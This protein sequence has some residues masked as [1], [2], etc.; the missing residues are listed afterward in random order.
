MRKLPIYPMLLFVFA[1][2]FNTSLFAQTLSISPEKIKSLDSLYRITFPASDPGAIIILAQGGKPVFK[3]A[4]GMANLENNVLL[5]TDHKMGI[6]SI[7]KQ[8]AAISILLLQQEGKLNIKDDIRKY[9]PFYNS[10]GKIITIENILSHTSGIPSYTE[11]N[12][13]D[14]IANKIIS[15]Y[16]L[17]KF[18]EKQPLLFDPGTNWSYT[19]SGYVLAGLIVEK[20]SGMSFNDFLQQRI[21]KPLLMTETT[22]GSSAF[23]LPGKS[24]EYSGPTPKGRMKVETQYNWYWAYAAGQIVSTV[25]DMLK[26]DEALYNPAFIRADLL[27]IAHTSFILKSGEDAH[28]G[29]GWAISTFKDKSMIQHGGSIG[30]YRAQGMRVPEDHLY[31]LILS[32]S[33]ITNASLTANKSLSILYDM[34]ALKENRENV[35][36]WKE[37]EG[38]YASPNAGLRLQSNFGSKEAY[39]TIRVDSNNRVTAQRTSAA[40]IN[41]SNAGKDLLFDKANPFVGWKIERNAQGIAEG[42][43]FTQ[44][45]PGYGPERYNKKIS[46][47]IPAKPVPGAIDSSGLVK[48]T[49]TFEHEFGDRVKIIIEK[50]QLLMEDP[51]IGTKTS[52]H[53]IS[54]N[55]FW[56]KETDMQV[57]FSTNIKGVISGLKYFNGFRDISMKRVEEIL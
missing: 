54:G 18:F 41:L 40:T 28:Y 22:L 51:E 27:K 29:T 11:L 16:Q 57:L 30:G 36:P 14:T 25:D 6:G 26:W 42:I 21:F 31:V 44:F 2:F 52:L 47:T 24:N 46:A 13:F 37:I 56:V 34:P 53:W 8:F 38:I 32:N 55:T 49:G 17:V 43:R 19:N 9:L 48:Y 12:G 45:F 39:Y 3:K 4:Y 35:Q 33:A 1:I 23:I 20:I 5:N 15:N 50:G 7:S 10:Y